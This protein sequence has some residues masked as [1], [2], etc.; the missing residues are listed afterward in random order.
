MSFA[1][2]SIDALQ[3]FRAAIEAEIA[4]RPFKAE[5]V[6]AEVKVRKEP[7]IAASWLSHVI[8]T[9]ASDYSAYKE[10]SQDKRGIALL[11]AKQW[12]AQ[13][14]EE[15]TLFE[16]EFKKAPAAAAAPAPAPAPAPSPVIP[17]PPQP[18]EKKARKPWSAEVKA[19][20]AAKRAAKKEAAPTQK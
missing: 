1:S 11:F 16:A 7:G 5:P 2:L 19:A 14:A 3:L 9:H 4:S 13:H 15:Y 12:R 8:K 6:K 20:A 17:Q 10:S 18:L